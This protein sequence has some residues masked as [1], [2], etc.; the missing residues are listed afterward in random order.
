MLKDRFLVINEPIPSRDRIEEELIND[1]RI[2]V[3]Y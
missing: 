3:K 1:E 2:W